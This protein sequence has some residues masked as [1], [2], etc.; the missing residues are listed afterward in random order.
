MRDIGHPTD[1]QLVDLAFDEWRRKNPGLTGMAT[2]PR[3]PPLRCPPGRHGK[4]CKIPS[5]RE[6]VALLDLYEGHRADTDAAFRD[7][8]ALLNRQPALRQ[9]WDEFLHA[10]GTSAED[11]R[12]WL[13]GERFGDGRPLPSRQHLRLVAS[14]ITI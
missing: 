3:F 8:L 2:R 11:L 14:R 10:G 12:C 13:S 4:P 9:V 5:A 1:D 7:I 6:L